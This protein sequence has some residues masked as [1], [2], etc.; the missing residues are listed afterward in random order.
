MVRVEGK[1]FS[2]S[3]HVNKNTKQVQS[4]ESYNKKVD[5]LARALKH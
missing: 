4:I 3:E 2:I 5:A 1:I